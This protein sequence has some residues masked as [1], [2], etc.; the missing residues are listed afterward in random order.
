M[1]RIE[2]RGVW[3]KYGKVEAVKDVSFVCED[4]ELFVL[5]GPSGAGKTS[6]LRMIAGLE[7]VSKGEILMDEQSIN[8]LK[9]QARNISMTFENYALYPHLTVFDNMAFSLKSPPR[10]GQYSS[11]DIMSRVSKISKILEIEDLL[12]RFPRQISGGQKQRVALGRTLIRENP[13]V[14]LLDEPIAHLDAKLRYNMRL[15]L[16]RLHR[17]LGYTII[18]ATPDYLEATLMGDRIAVIEKGMIHQ[19]GTPHEI[20]CNPASVTVGKLVGDPP[21]NFLDCAVFSKGEEVILRGD[22]FEIP[23][24]RKSS[25]GTALCNFTNG[26]EL[27]LGLRS[28]ES[29]VLTEPAGSKVIRGRITLVE[30]RGRESIVWLEVGKSLLRFRIPISAEELNSKHTLYIEPDIENIKIFDK[31][32]GRTIL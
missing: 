11:N 5:L 25:A 6:I 30:T 1:A 8:N 18:Y 22:N 2:L 10:R 14:C 19:V 29:R 3:K 21:M 24:L 28:R 32:S 15:R 23:I 27:L 16:K 20:I 9:P 7:S 12:D 26:K 31:K 13:H 17:E 4:G